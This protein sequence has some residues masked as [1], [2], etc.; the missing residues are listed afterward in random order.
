MLPFLPFL[1][2]HRS[3]KLDT[4]Q[5]PRPLY[6]SPTAKCLF[7]RENSIVTVSY[8]FIRFILWML[9]KKL[10]NHGPDISVAKLVILEEGLWFKQ[11][12]AHGPLNLSWISDTTIFSWMAPVSSGSPDWQE[13]GV[14]WPYNWFPGSPHTWTTFT[15]QINIRSITPMENIFHLFL[16]LFF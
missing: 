2:P 3:T 16:F 12:W 10:N 4:C 14:F 5:L 8:I 9:G 11:N 7:S 6:D 1:Y 13:N 15:N